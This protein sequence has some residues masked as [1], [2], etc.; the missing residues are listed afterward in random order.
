[1]QLSGVETTVVMATNS[2]FGGK[3]L[4]TEMAE[5]VKILSDMK[6]SDSQHLAAAIDG[7]MPR[8][9]S[10]VYSDRQNMQPGASP[11]PSAGRNDRDIGF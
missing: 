8:S 4:N 9:Q 1:M 10:M 2:G 11:T 6:E 7:L 3:A 5:A